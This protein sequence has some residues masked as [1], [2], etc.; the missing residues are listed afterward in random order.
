MEKKS[1]N[2]KKQSNIPNKI[3]DWSFQDAKKLFDNNDSKFQIDK[4]YFDDCI[5]GM[6]NIEDNSI[7]IIICDQYHN[8][9]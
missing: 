2:N 9:I 7:N 4:I 8:L 1:K 3:D 5:S 6:K